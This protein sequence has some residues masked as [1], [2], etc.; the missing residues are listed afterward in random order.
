MAEQKSNSLLDLG[1]TIEFQSDAKDK[2]GMEVVAVV[3][4][5]FFIKK[6][7]RGN[8]KAYRTIDGTVETTV[9]GLYNFQ[10][11]GKDFTGKRLVQGAP[12]ATEAAPA[13]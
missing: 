7:K 11:D 12:K 5:P 4:R 8:L 10:T 13:A 2:N 6:T 9:E 1:Y 3:Y